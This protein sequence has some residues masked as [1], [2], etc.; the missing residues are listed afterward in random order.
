MKVAVYDRYWST[1]GG[2]EKYAGGVAEVLSRGHDVT[3]IAHDE[4]DTDWLGE[5]LGLD[6]GR[7]TVTVVD[8]CE[9]LDRVSAGF[10]LLVNA[11]YRS[12]GCNG[13]R[14]GIYVVHFPDRPGADLSASRRTIA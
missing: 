12:H 11:S 8:E 13:A 4:V 7:T 10:D 5:R 1:A 14:H 2:G 9:P 6:L 3:L